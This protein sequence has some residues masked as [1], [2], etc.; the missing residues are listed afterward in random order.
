MQD[1]SVSLYRDLVVERARR[2]VHG[3]VLDPADGTGEGS[4]PL[5][6]DRVRVGVR[7]GEGGDAVEIRHHTRGCA[8]CAAS[9][10]LMADIVRG[11]TSREA[12]D[13]RAHFEDLLAF[14]ED[15]LAP[16]IR[17][18]LGPLLAFADLHDYKSRRKCATLPWSALLAA[19]KS[20]EDA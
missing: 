2:P 9:A 19:F 12:A 14:G 1:A 5:C 15:T 6:G 17:A 18:E 3:G 20:S 8:I 7:L 16:A 11:R 4:N 10:D 13:L